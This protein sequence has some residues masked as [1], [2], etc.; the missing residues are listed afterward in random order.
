MLCN[1]QSARN[2]C[3]YCAT[4]GIGAGC[5][6][7]RDWGAIAAERWDACGRRVCRRRVLAQP[8]P[9]QAAG[10]KNSRNLQRGQAIHAKSTLSHQHE[11]H[12]PWPTGDGAETDKHPSLRSRLRRTRQRAPCPAPVSPPFSSHHPRAVPNA[13][14]GLWH[15]KR[16]CGSRRQR[17]CD[18][19]SSRD[20]TARA[21]RLRPPP[22]ALLHQPVR[23][24]LRGHLRECSFKCAG[25]ACV[26]TQTDASRVQVSVWL[27]TQMATG[28]C[29]NAYPSTAKTAKVSGKQSMQ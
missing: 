17:A 14:F 16:R 21:D 24:H 29:N 12:A 4:D 20:Y 26:H 15:R 8:P 6:E 25:C 5:A 9:Q 7:E 10:P 28:G 19:A 13:A 2:R 3:R 23:V 11:R 1:T 18:H 27:K 22:C